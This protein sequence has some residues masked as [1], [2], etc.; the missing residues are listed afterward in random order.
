[1]VVDLERVLAD[2]AYVRSVLSLCK[3]LRE[4]CALSAVT[5][6]R[7]CHPCRSL[8]WLCA[9]PCSGAVRQAVVRRGRKTGFHHRDRDGS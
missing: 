6:V 7:G 4:E 3:L 9:P 8:L 2:V 5:L 1:M